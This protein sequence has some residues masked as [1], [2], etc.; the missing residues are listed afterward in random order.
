MVKRRPRQ[1]VNAR[2]T[3]L[4]QPFLP[5][6]D[7]VQNSHDHSSAQD[8]VHAGNTG[9]QSA[10][11]RGGRGVG[12]RGAGGLGAGVRLA[13]GHAGA[14]SRRLNHGGAGGVGEHGSRGRRSLG[15]S[16]GDSSSTGDRLRGRRKS[17]GRRSEAGVRDSRAGDRRRG[18]S[19]HED[20]RR[21]GGLGGIASTR[22][23]L[24]NQRSGDRSG[25]GSL[26]GA[27]RLGLLDDL[28]NVGC[29][30]LDG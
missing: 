21:G 29:G 11:S 15:A 9:C 6:L 2:T 25:D 7:V 3:P 30:L 18:S 20:G 26:A 5:S 24:G 8:T 4:I 13:S 16:A 1:Y 19:S 27:S 22:S 23:G 12:V 10:C 17:L 14:E 28:L